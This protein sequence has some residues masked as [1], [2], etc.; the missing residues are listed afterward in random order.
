MDRGAWW[1]TVHGVAESDMTEHT[2]R[3][4]GEGQGPVCS[5]SNRGIWLPPNADFNPKLPTLP[6]FLPQTF[7]TE[8]LTH[9]RLDGV[10]TCCLPGGLRPH[11]RVPGQ[12]AKGGVCLVCSLSRLHSFLETVRKNN[13]DLGGLLDFQI[14]SWI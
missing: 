8:H 4:G 12:A 9:P 10:P 7:C 2:H 3:C 6:L 13:S 11:D 1:A 14:H 5:T